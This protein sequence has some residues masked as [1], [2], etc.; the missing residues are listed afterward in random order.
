[1]TAYL[2]R[3]Q[4]E[5]GRV[6]SAPGR[7]SAPLVMVAEDHEDTRFLLRTVLERRGLAVVEAGDGEEAILLA[8]RA[9]PDLILMDGSLPRL[10]GIAATRRMR[11]MASLSAVPIVFLSGHAGPQQQLAAREAGC[12]DYLVKPLEL[13]SLYHVLER[14]LLKRG[15]AAGLR[16][17]N[18]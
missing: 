10:D 2:A 15:D 3:K 9:T 4:P 11:G 13:D 14:H 18:S 16:S 6:V 17:P 12:D 5:A 7:E 1:M 8:E